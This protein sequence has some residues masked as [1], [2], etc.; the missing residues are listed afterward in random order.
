MQ[1]HLMNDIYLRKRD[2]EQFLDYKI[3]YE[4]TVDN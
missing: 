2:R 3:Q 4:N 1:R